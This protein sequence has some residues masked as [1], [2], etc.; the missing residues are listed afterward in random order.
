MYNYLMTDLRRTARTAALRGSVGVFGAL[1]A[2]LVFLWYNPTF[3]AEQYA[4]KV[5][6][7]LGFFPFVVGLPVFLAVYAED[8]R[9][10]TLHTAIGCG[11]ARGCIVAAKLLESALLLLG[12]AAVLALPVLAA[13]VALGLDPDAGQLAGL[14]MTLG[15]KWLRALGYTAL[16]ALPV[17]CTQNALNGVILYVLLSSRT[18]YILLSLALGQSF[19]L[20]ALG[21]LTG[22]LF[23]GL[24]YAAKGQLLQG[25]G[26]LPPLLLAVAVYMALPTAASVLGFR[27]QELEL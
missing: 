12:A 15:A 6:G 17:F 18:V 7:V 3:T 4:A 16:A 25:P 27:K 24:L 14:A 5:T 8:F 19:V 20:D 13:P 21:D 22:W 10:R 9:C 26:G 23:T 11:V 2:V 1:W